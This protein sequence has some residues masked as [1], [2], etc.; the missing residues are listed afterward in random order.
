VGSRA[1]HGGARG[2]SPDRRRRAD[3]APGEGARG[4]SPDGRRRAGGAP[5]GGDRVDGDRGL[6]RRRDSPSPDWYHGRRMAQ[7][8][9]RDIG[10]GGG[11]PTLTKTNYVE[12]VEVMRVRLQVRQMWEAVQY[13][14]VDYHEDRRALDALIAAV[15][16]EMQFSL[17]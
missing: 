4:G 3:G 9:V 16:S 7:A 12:W 13:G 15:P 6:Y 10:P 17:S 8:I 5:G 2:G 1:P 11:W 14:N